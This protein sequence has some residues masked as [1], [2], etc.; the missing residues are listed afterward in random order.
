MTGHY[1]AARSLAYVAGYRRGHRHHTHSHTWAWAMAILATILMGMSAGITYTAVEVAL[2]NQS[3]GTVAP[4]RVIS[5]L[6]AWWRV[7]PKPS[8]PRGE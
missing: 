5:K 4:V 6:S 3:I 8:N 7:H 2:K 1:L